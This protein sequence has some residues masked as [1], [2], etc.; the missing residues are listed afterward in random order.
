MNKDVQK[1]W[2]DALE[3]GRWL[4]T[5][6]VMKIS[7]EGQNYHCCLGV[8]S[9]LWVAQDPECTMEM[10][11]ASFDTASL[12]RSILKWAG[13]DLREYRELAFCNDAGMSFLEIAD[14]L[15][16]LP[17]T[18]E[19]EFIRNERDMWHEKQRLR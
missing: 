15:R 2:I 8:L 7:H 6:D 5:K 17:E 19:N 13:G 1:L 18:E 3:S 16:R 4:Q 10:M 14:I 9:E 12:K 11:Y